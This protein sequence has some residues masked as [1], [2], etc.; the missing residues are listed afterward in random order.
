MDTLSEIDN[1][2]I[3]AIKLVNEDKYNEVSEIITA[4]LSDKSCLDKLTANNWEDIAHICILTRRFD[5]SKTAY[6]NA[7]NFEC[8]SFA[9]ILLNKLDDAKSLLKDVNESP[10]SLWCNFLI[11]LFSRKKDI[12]LPSFFMIRQFMEFTVYCLLLSN[13]NQFIQ[14][15][16][17]KLDKLLKINLDAEKL[18]GYAYLNFGMLDESIN[19]LNRA[20]KRDSL[21]GEIYFKLGQIYFLKKDFYQSLNMLNN[22]QLLLPGHYATKVLLEKVS[23]HLPK[24]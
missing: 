7:K 11:E 14:L 16:L 6:M 10:A 4:I 22:A 3:K 12:K 1:L 17:D 9:L 23:S 13:N 5:L 8:A 24:S 19:F 21:D 18:I 20:L 2:I 15:L